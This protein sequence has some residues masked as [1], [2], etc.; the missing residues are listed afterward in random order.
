MLL[1]ITG[2]NP[3]TFGS[4]PVYTEWNGK[5]VVELE[6]R[7]IQFGKYRYQDQKA[8]VSAVRKAMKTGKLVSFQSTI[9]DKKVLKSFIPVDSENPYVIGIVTDY[10]VIQDVLNRQLLNN[11]VISIIVLAL[12]LL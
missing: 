8:D 9:D 1:G 10:K 6:N 2:F 7:D 4:P 12:V 5:K 11:F 3:K